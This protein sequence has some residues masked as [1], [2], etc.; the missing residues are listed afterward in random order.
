MVQIM[1][2]D[3]LNFVSKPTATLIYALL[4]LFSNK[5]GCCIDNEISAN[6]L[7]NNITSR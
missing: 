6:Y 7:E 1:I 5:S 4:Y 2:S 3:M